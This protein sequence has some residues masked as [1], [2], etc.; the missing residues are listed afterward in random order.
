M[1]LGDELLLLRIGRLRRVQRELQSAPNWYSTGRRPPL[2]SRKLGVMRSLVGFVVCLAACA[3]DSASAINGGPSDASSDATSDGAAPRP[4]TV[5]IQTDAPW[6]LLGGT[7]GRLG[8]SKAI[9]PTT[10]HVRW[11]YD[12]AAPI[13]Y[14]S[15]VIDKSGTIYIGA[16][17]GRFVALDANGLLKWK[18]ELGAAIETTA[19]VA[20]DGTI[21]IGANDASLSAISPIGTTLRKV[22][23]NG[24]LRGGLTI[25][26]DGTV[27]F[28]QA[29]FAGGQWRADESL[30][31]SAA[32]GDSAIVAGRICD[33]YCWTSPPSL[34]AG[35]LI[36]PNVYVSAL[37]DN[38]DGFGMSFGNP[39]QLVSFRSDGSLRWGAAGPNGIGYDTEM[40]GV[41]A[42]GDV[43]ASQTDGVVMHFT[44]AGAYS[45]GYPI[46]AAPTYLRPQLTAAILDGADISYF[47]DV[48]GNVM[49]VD[50]QGTLVWSLATGSRGTSPCAMGADGTLY[51]GLVD[52]F[53]YAIGP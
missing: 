15:P 27:Y 21:Y 30:H 10:S 9:G 1:P 3:A 52:G 48:A 34:S 8:R 42:K 18:V 36:A 53:V 43:S 19:V 14:A 45:W 7:S 4:V 38:G 39:P 24:S 46:P 2:T 49:A 40:L 35:A 13:L 12:L 31:Y 37:E 5:G 50:A 32:G 20:Q 17:N 29:A 28:S 44:S 51:I 41:G 22:V 6:P 11:K 33:L 47:A 26:G 16:T 25:D 23:A